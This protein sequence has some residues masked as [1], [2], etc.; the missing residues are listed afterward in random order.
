M[1]LRLALTLFLCGAV[2]PPLRAQSASLH[3]SAIASPTS[4][5]GHSQSAHFSNDFD[6]EPIGGPSNSLH[7]VA[8]TGWTF[9]LFEIVGLVLN[10][11]TLTV[12]EGASTQLAAWQLLDDST[13]LAV[14]SSSVAWSINS[15][16]I[17][18]INP[19]GLASATVV[20]ADT[21][22]SLQGQFAGF[23]GNLTLTVKNIQTDDFGIYAADGIDD[24]WQNQYFGLD[25]PQAG[26]AVDASHTGQTNLFKYLAGLNPTDPHSRFIVAI[27]P[28]SGATSPN[29]ITF[30]PLAPGRTYTVS[31]TTDLA[32]GPWTP[33]ANSSVTDNGLQRTVIDSSPTAP[34]RFYRVEIAKP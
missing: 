24:A 29:T 32:L 9:S 23:T 6:G 16:P 28:P 20:F 22:A 2:A 31:S 4:F 26:P 34:K 8:K 21:P 10:S 27:A 30:S 18:T 12:N 1:L 25:N 17:S 14:P 33:L 5:G 3:Y 11:S 19:S 7:S 13:F 15:G